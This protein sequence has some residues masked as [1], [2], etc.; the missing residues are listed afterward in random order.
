MLR[1]LLIAFAA[2]VSVAVV[3][4]AVPNPKFPWPDSGASTGVVLLSGMVDSASITAAQCGNPWELQGADFACTNFRN[5]YTVPYAFTITSVGLSVGSEAWS[6]TGNCDVRVILGGSPETSTNFLA[7]GD[8]TATVP[9]SVDLY[10]VGD[11]STITGLS[12]SVAAGTLVQ[13]RHD[14]PAGNQSCQAGAGCVCTAA[15]GSYKYWIRG[16]WN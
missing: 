5:D 3:S 15:T 14:T 9:A 1:N 16:T 7:G 6:A 11:S 13:V 2:A 10:S 4:W 12:I 8:T